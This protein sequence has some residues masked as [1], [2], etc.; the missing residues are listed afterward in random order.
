MCIYLRNRDNLTYN[1]REHIFP[2]A[3]GGIHTLEKG[4]VSDQA[5]SIFCKLED[6][7]I[8]AS[9]VSLCRGF[10]GP[11]KRGSNLP[12]GTVRILYSLDNNGKVDKLSLG[13]M[14]MGKAYHIPHVSIL[15][16]SFSFSDE[17]TSEKE[18]TRSFHKFLNML[19]EFN[20]SPRFVNITPENYSND[21]I[22][23]LYCRN[24]IESPW[25]A[26]G[27]ENPY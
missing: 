15:Y 27:Q 3:I 11:G 25:G 20:K 17:Y 22:I 24:L 21:T 9:T 16:N 10:S 1:G 6:E 26:D 19:S 12:S 2:A 7:M 13:I 4:C 14:S 18:L 23:K 8:H 5:N